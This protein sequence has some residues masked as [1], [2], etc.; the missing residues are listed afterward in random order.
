MVNQFFL[1][2]DCF[3]PHEPWDP[4]LRYADV[5]YSE[6]HDPRLIFAP[7][8]RAEQFGEKETNRIKALYAG[9]VTMVDAWIGRVLRRLDELNLVENT[10]V[11]FTSDHGTLLGE[12]GA[13]HKQHWGLVQ[14]ETRLPL[15]M[16]LPGGQMSGRRVSGYVS[17]TDIAPTVLS[18]LGQQVPEFMDGRNLVDIASG[19]QPVRESVVSAY[20]LYASIRT[21]TH[22][23]I[24][25]YRDLAGTRWERN[26]QPPRL[27][28][29]DNR[30][31]EV[32]DVTGQQQKIELQLQQRLNELL[33][34]ME[35]SLL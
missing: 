14:P 13:I 31:C 6:Y 1:W 8:V 34:S 9:E 16:R 10:A 24:T 26:P 21:R 11:I 2:V 3:D 28:A 5:Y 29:L 30:L 19:K 18:L 12:M 22:N 35:G 25:P 27:F 15:I 33:E 20:G 23:Y 4:P 32:Q 7:S 17:A